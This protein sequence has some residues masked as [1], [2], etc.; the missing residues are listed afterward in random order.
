MTAIKLCGL[1]TEASVQAALDVDAEMIGLNFFEPSPRYVSP[2]SAA[3]LAQIIRRQ[4]AHTTE[5]IA[6]TVNMDDE[7]H[8]RIVDVLKPDWI[9]LHGKETPD[10]VAQIKKKFDL[11]VMK[12]FGIS[13]RED[14]AQLDDYKHVVDRFLFDAKPPKDSVLPGGNGAAFDW[15]LMENL[16]LGKPIVLSGGLD[17]DNVAEA[18]HI[19]RPA[20]VDVSSG[21]ESGKGIKD[22]DKI[23][24]FAAAVRNADAG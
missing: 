15:H 3:K 12:A 5:I 1:S 17:K 14:L 10:R 19:T 6:L 13:T 22:L 9:Q 4:T 24:A 11:P 21:I 8:S 16:E 23:R 20:A 18:I 2:Q 7:G